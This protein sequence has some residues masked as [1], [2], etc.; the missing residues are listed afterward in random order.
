MHSADGSQAVPGFA[1][2]YTWKLRPTKEAQ[3]QDAWRQLTQ[4]LQRQYGA[5]GSQLHRTGHDTWVAYNPWPDK[6]CWEYS[7]AVPPQAQEVFALLREAI[8]MEFPPV[9]IEPGDKL[10]AESRQ[11]GWTPCAA[12]ADSVQHL[13]DEA[14]A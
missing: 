2:L 1:V 5:L 8:A 11:A 14:Q 10:W 3:F 6:D 4:M 9:F 12:D 13:R 7:Q